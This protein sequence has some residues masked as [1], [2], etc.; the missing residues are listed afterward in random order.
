MNEWNKRAGFASWKCAKKG[1][2]ANSAELLSES[3]EECGEKIVG[4]ID[5]DTVLSP[6]MWEAI[7]WR[8]FILVMYIAI[9]ACG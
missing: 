8:L 2:R 4:K 6:Y 9:C 3:D 7:E 5:F 1:K